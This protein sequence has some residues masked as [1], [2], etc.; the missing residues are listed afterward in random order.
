MS[1]KD[2]RNKLFEDFRASIKTP[3]AE[4]TNRSSCRYI[5]YIRLRIN[6]Y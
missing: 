2:I 5:M 3:H 1:P 4:N 6:K